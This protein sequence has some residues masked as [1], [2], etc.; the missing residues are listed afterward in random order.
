MENNVDVEQLL[1]NYKPLVISISRRYYLVGAELDDIIQEGMIGLYKSIISYNKDK[2]NNFLNYA[3]LCIKRQILSAIKKN[4]SFKN[5]F[6]QE[7]LNEDDFYTHE[8]P[9]ADGNPENKLI[10]KEDFSN[11]KQEILTKLT[12]YEKD[13]LKE[14][15]NGKSYEEIA[16]KLS[17]NK[18]SVD[19]ALSRI[20]R[21]L[22]YLKK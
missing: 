1:E 21:K 14:Y 5:S 2:N 16:I 8:V 13:I 20:R 7:L 19:N 11:L 17:V 9:S 22:S 10:I 15:L 18:K 6:F 4:Q 12:N 3:S